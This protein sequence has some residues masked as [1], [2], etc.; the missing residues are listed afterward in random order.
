MVFNAAGL[1]K[2]LYRTKV[3]DTTSITFIEKEVASWA[4]NNALLGTII[5]N[6]KRKEI[7]ELQQ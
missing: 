3:D 1:L 2:L 5:K 7:A 4:C 6:D